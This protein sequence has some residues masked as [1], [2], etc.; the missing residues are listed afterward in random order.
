MALFLIET[1]Y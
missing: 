1:V